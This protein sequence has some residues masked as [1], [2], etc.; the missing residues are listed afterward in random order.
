M[1]ALEFTA[2]LVDSGFSDVASLE[3]VSFFRSQFSLKLVAVCAV[4]M[5]G[6]IPLPPRVSIRPD[7]AGKAYKQALQP[8]AGRSLFR[9]GRSSCSAGG[10]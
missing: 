6:L 9:T 4:L 3:V 7:W 2:A 5:I 8:L 10:H 1:F